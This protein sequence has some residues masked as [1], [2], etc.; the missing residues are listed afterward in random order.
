MLPV[1][2]LFVLLIGLAPRPVFSLDPQL[3][4]DQYTVQAWSLDHG[5][6]QSTVNAMVQSP[7]GYVYIATFGGLARFDG[8]RMELIPEESACG[9]R[10]TSLA[11]DQGGVVWVG[12]ERGSIC[13]LTD[14]KLSQPVSEEAA[15]IDRV[16]TIHAGL[17]GRLWIGAQ[18]GLFELAG[19]S[20]RSI[21]LGHLADP[22]V[23]TLAQHPDDGVL[24]VGTVQ[25]LCLYSDATCEQPAWASRFDDDIIRVIHHADDGTTWIGTEFELFRYRSGDVGRIDLPEGL[26]WIYS[27]TD[28]QHG[29]VWIATSIAGLTRVAPRLEQPSEDSPLRAGGAVSLLSDREGNLWT[30]FI[31]RGIKKLAEGRAYGVRLSRFSSVQP[32]LPVTVDP[33]GE[34]WA[35]LPCRGL[36]HFGEHGTRLF[37]GDN[38]FTN[39]C[40]W[41]LLPMASGEVWVGTH[42]GGLYRLDAEGTVHPVPEPG[43]RENIVRALYEDRAGHILIGTDQG[44]FRLQPANSSVEL[45]PGTEGEDVFFLTEGADGALW[46][47][48]RAGALRINGNEQHRFDEANGL[49]GRQVRVIHSDADGVIWIGTYGGGLNRIDGDQVFVFDRSNGMPDDIVSSL[50]EDESGRFWMSANRGVMRV[51]RASLNAFAAGEVDAIEVMLLDRNDGMPASETNGGAQPAGVLLDDGRLW[52]PTVDGLAVFDT[53]SDQV[54]ALPPPVLIEQVLLDGEPIDFRSGISLPAG[55]RNLE[56]HYTA[57]SFRAPERVN[58]RYR[59]EGFDQRWVEAGTRRVAYFPVIPSGRL[60]FQVIAANHDGLWSEIGDGFEFEV[61]P[62]WAQ[63]PELYLGLLLAALLAS[64]ILARL[65]SR[66]VQQRE[67]E[68]QSEVNQRTAELAK[69]A[70]LTEY[71]NRAVKLQQVLDHT[72]ETLHEFVPYDHMIL[73]LVDSERLAIRTLW[74]RRGELRGVQGR[75]FGGGFRSRGLTE[76]LQTGQPRIIDDLA[77]YLAAHPDSRSTRRLMDEGIKSSMICPL[78]V[79]DQAEGF[80]LLA[81]GQAGAYRDTHVD[82]LKQLA[83]QLALAVSKSRLY[84]EL[85]EA[86]RELESRNQQLAALASRDELTGIANRRAFEHALDAA[87]FTAVKER[88]LISILMVDVDWFKAFNDALGHQAGDDCLRDIASALCETVDHEQATVARV[89]GEEFAVILPE[90]NAS[91]ALKLGQR[92]CDSIA[93]LSIHH[94]A[95]ADQSHVTISAGAATL[96]ATPD[97]SRGELMRLADQALYAAKAG[98]RNQVVRAG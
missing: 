50:F 1:T 52:I 51:S 13:R 55:A 59:L 85:L 62:G 74:S 35:G 36:V 58:F 88:A 69:L 94:P 43:T 57:L 63:R 54:N 39:T 90:T 34:I 92:L 40:V 23:H 77:D 44:V 31:G 73:A 8:V 72:Y 2:I 79:G 12:A 98:G 96:E 27:L 46:V 81:S 17:D 9:R 3:G 64:L 28:D 19:E 16:N 84:D 41:S 71:I 75:E 29:N 53:R 49:A 80:L 91:Q 33:S 61:R 47:G 45:V 97:R 11:V 86:K 68:L 26:G 14:G 22:N 5:L 24:W 6:P 70:E 76:V 37:D 38:G 65:R 18:Y 67:R 21:D 10:Y 83:S 4:I 25:G 48:T 87:W 30:G 82:F 66:W 56:I 60:R 93:E 42:G 15:A 7:L 32:F 78:R 89:G 95:A 20:V